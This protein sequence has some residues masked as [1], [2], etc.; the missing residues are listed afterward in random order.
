M[1][2]FS[3]SQILESSLHDLYVLIPVAIANLRNHWTIGDF[4]FGMAIALRHGVRE[5]RFLRSRPSGRLDQG[6]EQHPLRCAT[7]RAG[8]A[9][10]RNHLEASDW[11]LF[12]VLGSSSGEGR[13]PTDLFCLHLCAGGVV[14]VVFSWD[15]W[16][17]WPK[18]GMLVE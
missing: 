16:R 18:V 5:G 11:P 14:S 13:W 17:S 2:T 3:V 4:H 6:N 15:C 1:L 8:F 7:R 9:S 12:G 10:M